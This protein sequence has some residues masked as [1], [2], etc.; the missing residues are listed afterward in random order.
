MAG[1]VRT[2]RDL[3]LLDPVDEPQRLHS[4]PRRTELEKT[5]RALCDMMGR[6]PLPSYG[7]MCR[8]GLAAGF[9]L[10]ALV[11]GRDGEFA[12]E[13]SHRHRVLAESLHCLG[14]RVQADIERAADE[15]VGAFNEGRWSWDSEAAFWSDILLRIRSSLAGPSTDEQPFASLPAGRISQPGLPASPPGAPELLE[16]LCLDSQPELL[17]S[18]EE[19]VAALGVDRSTAYRWAKRRGFPAPVNGRLDYRD[20]A[21][22]AKDNLKRL[23]HLAIPRVAKLIEDLRA[24]SAENNR[25]S[26]EEALGRRHADELPHED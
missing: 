22:W 14:S 19:A 25:N 24:K 13:V 23:D 7:G 3:F 1:Q 9:L 10:E 12:R 6:E 5:C 17:V 18:V 20:V 16:Q 26:N 2:R 4:V 8:L 11:A 21:R 15:C